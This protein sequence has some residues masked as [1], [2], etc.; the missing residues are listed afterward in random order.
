[1]ATANCHLRTRPN[2]G[3]ELA[4]WPDGEVEQSG[5]SVS[6]WLSTRVGLATWHALA[7]LLGKCNDDALRPADVG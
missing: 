4:T 5:P 7:K 2:Y 6:A 1:M 3:D